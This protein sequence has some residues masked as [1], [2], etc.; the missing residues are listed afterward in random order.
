MTGMH[1]GFLT[2]EY[3][4]SSLKS[5]G[6]GTFIRHI[7]HLLIR[8]P[9]IAD[10][11]VLYWG[12]EIQ[13]RIEDD[14]IPIIPIP[15][16]HHNKIAFYTNRRFLCKALEKLIDQEK[17]DIIE[18]I[19]WEGPLAFCRL[20]IPVVTRLHGSNVYFNSLSNKRTP[21]LLKQI[22]RQALRASTAY[23]GVS[24]QALRHTRELFRLS[25]QKKKKVIYNPIDFDY[26]SRF[27][28]VR[29]DVTDDITILYFGT[30]AEKK[31]VLDIPLIFNQLCQTNNRVRLKLIGR[32]AIANGK[33]TWKSCRSLFSPPRVLNHVNYL[34]CLP[35]DETLRHIN[36]ADICLFPSH[37]ETFG[38]V[39]LEA[40][41]MRKAIVCS[42]IDCFKEIVEDG[43]DAIQCTVGDIDGFV[44]ALQLLL[45]DAVK[46]TELAENAHQKA[47]TKFD[48]NKIVQENISFYEELIKDKN[49][50]KA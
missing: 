28:R 8:R 11:S 20:P 46:R 41:F 35:Y 33:S 40:M 14:G 13:D 2:T 21:W 48:T 1:I 30:I 17:L 36:E 24:Q 18:T 38:L 47:V 43:K 9:E 42:D 37:A 26:I 6:I 22:E 12:N 49:T 50:R 4:I 16:P 23:I 27:C 32:D 39:L 19:D 29:K 15:Q 44:S 34:G 3:P 7:S 31:G 5:G 25:P 45:N 10:V